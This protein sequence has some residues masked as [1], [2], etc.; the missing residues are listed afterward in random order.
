[1]SEQ[2]KYNTKEKKDNL[3][4]E[5]SDFDESIEKQVKNRLDTQHENL[6]KDEELVAARHEVLRESTE[7]NYVLDKLNAEDSEKTHN[8]EFSNRPINSELKKLTFTKEIKHIRS[9]L[10][11][12]DQ[13]GSK[14]IHQPIIRSISETSSKTITRPS[15]LLGGGITAFLGTSIYVYLTKHIG[16]KYNYSIF[17][18]FLIGGF[19]LGV[20]L[21]IIVRLLKRRRTSI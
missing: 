6:K 17:L 15:G 19:F 4:Y 13:L 10:N 16:L 7:K 9:K 3:N 14:I 20:F 5:V 2:H 11:K 21:E 8:I 12:T 18:L 1:M